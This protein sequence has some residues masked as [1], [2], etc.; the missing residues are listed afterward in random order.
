MRIYQYYNY[1]RYHF[2]LQYSMATVGSG[3]EL[4]P[5]E[6]KRKCLPNVIMMLIESEKLSFK[7]LNVR[8]LKGRTGFK[9]R[10]IG[11]ETFREN[12]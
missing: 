4:H 10:Q 2:I 3:S 5:Y 7:N 8:L 6:Y 9:S 1:N 11:Y 12:T